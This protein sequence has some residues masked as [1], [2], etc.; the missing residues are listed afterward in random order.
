MRTPPLS[1][2]LT[3]LHDL[4]RRRA[5]GDVTQCARRL[6]VSEATLYRYLSLLRTLGGPIA[7]SPLDRT[8]YYTEPV[9]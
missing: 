3:R 6:G 5:T 4:I 8:Y 1:S 7:Y 2:Q 9:D